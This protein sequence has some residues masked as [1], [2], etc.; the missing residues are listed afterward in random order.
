MIELNSVHNL[1]AITFLEQLYEDYGDES[2]N[3]FLVDFPYTFKGKQRVTANPWDLPVDIERFFELASRM[4]TYEG[5][6]C[7]TATQPFASYLITKNIEMITSKKY[8]DIKLVNFK[9]DWIWEK[10]N[11]S[12]FVHVNHQPFKVHESLLVFGKAPTTYN[13]K[14]SIC[15]TTL[16]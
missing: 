15:F 6:I 9:Y 14:V 10:D 5:C 13:K 3:M 16:K 7:L 1:E 2:I 12:N 4:L 8:K 11:G